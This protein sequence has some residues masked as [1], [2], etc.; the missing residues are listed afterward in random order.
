MPTF[1]YI[2]RIEEIIAKFGPSFSPDERVRKVLAAAFAERDDD[3]EDYLDVA[4]S[5]TSIGVDMTASQ[6]IV[7]AN[8]TPVE[9]ESQVF[10]SG[11]DFDWD[12]LTTIT[13]QRAGVVLVTGNL[14]FDPGGGVGS[15]SLLLNGGDVLGGTSSPNNAVLGMR[16]CVTK[17]LV[18]AEGDSLEMAA[19]QTS[20]GNLNIRGALEVAY[21]SAEQ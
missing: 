12:G 18:V 6:T 5:V 9:F 2:S 4:T 13:T 8:V 14:N 17:H 10:R 7:N 11:E 20:G 15:V 3:L 1:Q 16:G 21:R 19:F